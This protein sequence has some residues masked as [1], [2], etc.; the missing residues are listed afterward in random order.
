MHARFLPR[1][2]VPAY[3]PFGFLI[4]HSTPCA[5]GSGEKRDS[6]AVMQQ[7]NRKARE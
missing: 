7:G 4:E 5:S 3:P 6:S 2:D 1:Q